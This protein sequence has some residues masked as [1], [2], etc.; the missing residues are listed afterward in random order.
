MNWDLRSKW[1]HFCFTNNYVWRYF[2]PIFHQQK[3][4]PKYRRKRDFD[5]LLAKPSRGDSKSFSILQSKC[6]NVSLDCMAGL[7]PDRE[8]SSDSIVQSW[9]GISCWMTHDLDFW[10]ELICQHQISIEA[11]TNIIIVN[12]DEPWSSW[13]ISHAHEKLSAIPDP[14]SPDLIGYRSR[15]FAL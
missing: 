1:R 12:Q 15:D 11:V 6:W 3:I 10:K 9:V 5:W 7:V 8:N 13:E 4:F 14:L 2:P